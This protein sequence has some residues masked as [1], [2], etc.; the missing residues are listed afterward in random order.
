MKARILALLVVA[1]VFC[2]SMSMAQ[3]NKFDVITEFPG[4]YLKWIH[5][6]EPEFKRRNM[7]LDDYKITVVDKGES[8]AVFIVSSD[9]P[10]NCMGSCG[11][12]PAYDVEISKK[13]SKMIRQNY[14]R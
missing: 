5:I 10:E 12:H 6:A 1:S 14:M 3:S 9:A 4:G 11:S 7:N 8:I 13:D 2:G